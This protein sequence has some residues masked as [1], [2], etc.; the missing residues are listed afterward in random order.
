MAIH[1]C[2]TQFD[3]PEAA[4]DKFREA[5]YIF[6]AA[7]ILA[8][9]RAKIA[10]ERFNIFTTLLPA[11]DEV[12]LHTRFLHCLLDP[13]GLHDC[14]S[15]FLHLFFATLAGLPVEYENDAKNKPGIP[16]TE[17]L[18]TVEREAPRDEV[19]RM[20]LLLKQTQPVFGIAI[21]NK[22][23]ADEQTDQIWRYAKF[24]TDNF[25]DDWCLFY[26]TLHGAKS[27]THNG[28]PYICIS[29]SKHIL[30]WLEKCISATYLVPQIHQV[31]LQYRQLV[32]N[33]TDKNA[34][35]NIMKTVTDFVLENPNIMQYRSKVLQATDAAFV[36]FM[37]R[38]AAGILD[39]I[40]MHFKARLRSGLGIDQF[41]ANPNDA[42]IITPPLGSPPTQKPFEIWVAHIA[43]FSGAWIV[44]IVPNPSELPLKPEIKALFQ[45]MDKLLDN[46]REARGWM[47]ADRYTF[48]DGTEWPTGWHN[49]IDPLIDDVAKAGLLKTPIKEKAAKVCA[50]IRFHVDL[51]ERV[52]L[53]ASSSI[54]S[55]G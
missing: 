16:A 13:N 26:L 43:Q 53:K 14:G 3:I 47:K 25:T 18:W 48:Y 21:E 1:H 28:Q 29:Y 11:D 37:S 40:T 44:G 33:L 4:L 23:Y 49:L 45:S 17:Q 10:H 42:F 22:I 20:D 15:L 24:L 51:L 31:I 41:V 9:D 36:I 8:D 54:A 12:R 34:D 38:L 27:N 55:G 52:Y 5:A 30:E 46:E 35:S 7:E 19:G 39:G 6:A 32:E 2:M 50:D